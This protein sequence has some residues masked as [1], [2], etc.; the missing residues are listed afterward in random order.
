MN[1]VANISA[2]RY[3]IEAAKTVPEIKDA[4]DKLDA[5][6][7]YMRQSGKYGIEEIVEVAELK[8]LA[9]WK[10]GGIL[11]DELGFGRPNKVSIN[12]T[13]SK[14]GLSRDVSSQWQKIAAIPRDELEG[15]LAKAREDSS[16]I[17][18]AAALLKA[19]QYFSRSRRQHTNHPVEGDMCVIDDLA[20]AGAEGRKFGTIYAD[21]PWLYGNQGTRAS[22]DNHYDGMTVEE[23]AAM[24]V[25]DLAADESHL[26]LW[27]TNAFLFDAKTIIEAWGFEYKS[28][29]LWVKPQ[30][31]I[32]NYWRVSHEFLL[33]GVRGNLTFSDRAQ[34]SWLEAKRGRHSAKP[35]QV[36][37]IIEKTSPGPRLELFARSVVENWAV[38]GNEIEQNLFR[39]G[40]EG[41]A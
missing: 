6:H 28:C 29:F 20:T 1:E 10:G 13:L 24:P 3:Q 7:S 36:R 19:K 33:L 12:P 5:I 25:A 37:Q 21:P 15:M 32:G 35:E 40:M 2:A 4:R 18:M 34:M 8:L 27:T 16:P 23:I 39:Q 31:G 41:A 30:M 22:T 11:A 14:L 38:W 26:H 17:T 9:E